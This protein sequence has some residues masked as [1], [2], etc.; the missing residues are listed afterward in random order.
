MF[1]DQ[2]KR[3]GNGEHKLSERRKGSQVIVGSKDVGRDCGGEVTSEFLLVSTAH[4]QC[5]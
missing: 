3:V 5:P 4:N 2:M 1:G